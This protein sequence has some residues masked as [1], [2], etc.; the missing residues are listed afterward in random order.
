MNI[1]VITVEYLDINYKY[2]F[3]STYVTE[4]IIIISNKLRTKLNLLSRAGYNIC[5]KNIFQSMFIV[6]FQAGKMFV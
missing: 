4:V 1:L 6:E 2:Q 3:F 5:K